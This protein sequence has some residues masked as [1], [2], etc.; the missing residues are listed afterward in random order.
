MKDPLHAEALKPFK[1]ELVL[2][3]RWAS[4][5]MGYREF[6]KDLGIKSEDVHVVSLRNVPP[7]IPPLKGEV[8]FFMFRNEQDFLKV[9]KFCLDQLD[10]E[11]VTIPPMPPAAKVADGPV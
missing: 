7:F 9:Q 1:Y 2:D 11:P 6:W 3:L 5:N 4:Q 10:L 8:A